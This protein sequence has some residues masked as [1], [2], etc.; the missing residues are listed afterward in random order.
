MGGCSK[1]TEDFQQFI[2]STNTQREQARSSAETQKCASLVFFGLPSP[3]DCSARAALLVFY[4]WHNIM[5]AKLSAIQSAICL[6]V[7]ESFVC[8]ESSRG[9]G[10]V[11][12]WPEGVWAEKRRAGLHFWILLINPT[13]LPFV[14]HVTSISLFQVRRHWQWNSSNQ[15]S[16]DWWMRWF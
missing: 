4:R 1:W 13:R 5:T 11:C 14:R 2:L 6:S 15:K 10:R 12:F 8:G 9:K 3:G 7:I 16:D